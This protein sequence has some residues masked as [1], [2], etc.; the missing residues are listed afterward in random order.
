[1]TVVKAGIAAT[2]QCEHVQSWITKPAQTGIIVSLGANRLCRCDERAARE[3]IRE[4]LN[5]IKL[6][7]TGRVRMLR[8]D[9]R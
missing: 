4:N 5:L 1:L 3:E 9:P 6:G 7:G 8:I 2:G